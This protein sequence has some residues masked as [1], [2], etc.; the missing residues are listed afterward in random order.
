MR[1]ARASFG[2]PAEL[3][4][5]E[6][7]NA[8]AG[9]HLS[10]ALQ[11]VAY[12]E[13]LLFLVAFPGD[14]ET[15][16][17]ALQ[18]LDRFERRCRGLTAE[19]RNGLVN[20]GMAGTVTRPSLAWPVIRAFAG[21]DIELEWNHVEA[22]EALDALVARLVSPAERE[23]F[24]SG[25]YT[26]RRW[27]G[28][29]RR[30]GERD[31]AWLIRD[32]SA[33]RPQSELA[34]AWDTAQVPLRWTLRNSAR[35]VTHARLRSR[36]AR[37]RTGFRRLT[38]TAA[39]HVARP[40]EDI[41]RL[42]RPQAAEVVDLARSALAVRAREVHAMNYP[43]LDEVY[44]ADLGEGAELVL[45][46]VPPAHRLTFEAN[47]GYLLMSNGV[48]V[49]Y[50]GVTPLYRQANTG[51]NV[52]DPFRGSEAAFLWA[53]TLRTF[54]TLFG[55]RR[56]V[57]NGYQFGAGNPEAIASGAYWFY[58]RLGFRPSVTENVELAAQELERLRHEPAKRTPPA[59]LRRLA[60]GDLHFDLHDFDA[61]DF[62]DESLLTR[63]GAVLARRLAA[64]EIARIAKVRTA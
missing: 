58:L 33:A 37:L 14:A 3:R 47:Y 17:A 52:F 9:K 39:M 25:D 26:T 60:Q 53:Q 38:E 12:H 6:L 51:I 63:I 10:S 44:L 18:E 13:D 24:E 54:R 40:L 22:P 8:L 45:I 21:E 56:F 34:N 43:N 59:T 7:L 23:S 55:M 30:T 1:A 15:R 48:P 4:K 11:L 41:C 27:V 62:F 5:R 49:G 50:G 2:E 36:R 28:L 64:G 61:A 19:Q 57:I 32:G 46:G 16:G 42:G 31:L 35:S 20:S 29:A